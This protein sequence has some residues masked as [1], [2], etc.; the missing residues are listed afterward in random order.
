MERC[1]E[2]AR[3]G[4]GMVAPNPMVGSVLVYNGRIIG[5]GY[6]QQYGQAHAEVNC[7]NS[8]APEDI[9][10]IPE[11]VIYVSLEPC[12]HFGKTP[13]CADLVIKHRIKKVVIGCRDPFEE[14]NGKGIEKLQAAG[15]EV[16][17]GVMEQSCKDLNKHFFTFHNRKRPYIILKWA[18]SA[19]GFMGASVQPSATDRVLISND[20]TNRLVHKWRS[21]I[22]SILIGTE[23]ALLD[24]PALTTRLWPGKNPTRLVIDRSLR[25]PVTLKVFDR[26]VTTIV[27]N[28]I[29]SSDEDGLIYDKVADAEIFLEAVGKALFQRNINSVL[30]E[31]GSRLLQSFINAGMWDEARII[32]NRKLFLKEGVK[33]PVLNRGNI[34][35]RQ[36][37]LDDEVVFVNC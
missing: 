9:N 18:Q 24:D 33:A 14:V 23:T 12:A 32:T 17:T 30:V 37:F 15:I 21:E 10:L 7:I 25:L 2:L 20:F 11:S 22:T 31:G 27:F 19:D 34:V 29:T 4:A 28:R 13:P 3:L 16:I 36:Q 6:H 26:S 1:I 5:E 8:V 35:Q